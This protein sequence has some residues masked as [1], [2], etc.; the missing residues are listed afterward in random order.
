MSNR[1]KCPEC[2]RDLVGFRVCLEVLKAWVPDTGDNCFTVFEDQEDTQYGHAGELEHAFCAK[3]RTSY[4]TMTGAK[5]VEDPVVL[6]QEASAL[7]GKALKDGR[8]PKF[9]DAGDMAMLPKVVK[10]AANTDNDSNSDP[11]LLP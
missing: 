5:L 11:D 9:F 1:K 10:A 3:C 2:G 7:I 8:R 4:D 6:L